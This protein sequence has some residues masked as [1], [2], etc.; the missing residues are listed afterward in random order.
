MSFND[1]DRITER[2]VTKDFVERLSIGKIFTNPD[3]NNLNDDENSKLFNADTKLK[4][5]ILARTIMG[6]SSDYINNIDSTKTSYIKCKAGA[7]KPRIYVPKDYLLY[8]IIHE[9]TGFN[10]YNIFHMLYN[11]TGYNIFYFDTIANTFNIDTGLHSQSLI[12]PGDIVIIR[13]KN[14]YPLINSDPDIYM[15]F[16][17]KSYIF[18]PNLIKNVDADPIPHELKPNY[19]LEFEVL[20]DSKTFRFIK[21]YEATNFIVTTENDIINNDSQLNIIKITEDSNATSSAIKANIDSWP[22]GTLYAITLKTNK[23]L[24]PSI[25]SS[26]NNKKYV[27]NNN[28]NNSLYKAGSVIKVFN[29]NGKYIVVNDYKIYQATLDSGLSNSDNIFKAYFAH[30]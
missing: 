19:V 28:L 22:S 29:D 18:K 16:D 15:Y 10:V 7:S 5:N 13:F 23:T 27:L 2:E 21:S 9:N 8:K 26:A 17:N 4:N 24:Y 3:Y 6:L 1:I 25:V 11:S 30:I 14:G 20:N 12:K